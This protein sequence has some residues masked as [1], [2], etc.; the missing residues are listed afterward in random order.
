MVATELAI[1]RHRASLAAR[2]LQMTFARTLEITRS[3]VTGAAITPN[4]LS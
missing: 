4:R 2:V 1:A 3:T